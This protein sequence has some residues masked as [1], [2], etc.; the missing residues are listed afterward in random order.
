MQKKSISWGNII[1]MFIIFFPIGIWLLVKKM[2]TETLDYI[3]NG[4][5]LRLFGWVLIIIAFMYI[6]MGIGGQFET[7]SPSD[8]VSGIVVVLVIFGGTGLISLIKARSFI[9]KGKKYERYVY[10]VNSTDETSIDNIAA[11]YPTSYEQAVKDLQSMINDG[12]LREAHLDLNN[13]EFIRKRKAAPANENQPSS[14][15]NQVTSVKCKN[16]GATNT[17]V[18]GTVNECEYCGSPLKI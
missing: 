3:K 7:E 4:K 9:D 8:I 10:I 1:L 12:Y 2:T 15:N 17:V 16:C 13:R 18:P 11:A 6:F 14:S 5:S